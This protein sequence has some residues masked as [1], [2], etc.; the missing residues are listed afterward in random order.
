MSPSF[1]ACMESGLK[2]AIVGCALGTS[3][4]IAVLFI[5]GVSFGGGLA[6]LAGF[7]GFAVGF[8]SEATGTW[9]RGRR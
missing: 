7:I 6:A 4:E 9:L 8:L 5:R 1:D 2:S 3:V